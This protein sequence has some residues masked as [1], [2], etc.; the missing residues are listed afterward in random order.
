MAYAFR[1]HEPKTQGAGV[2][3]PVAAS[4]M[5]GWTAT[6]EIKG[7]LL[8]NITIQSAH[9]KMGTSI[10]SIF[11]RMFLFDI[12][13]QSFNGRN[14]TDLTTPPENLKMEASLVA[15]CLDLMEF[16]FQHGS[17]PKLV[18]KHWNSAAQIAA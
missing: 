2:T 13:F 15:E 1:I 3:A 17:D 9:G 7:S 16:L 6:S 11:A 4:T 5:S 8:S 12:A 14:I 18:I 10:P